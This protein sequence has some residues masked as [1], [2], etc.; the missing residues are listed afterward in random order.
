MTPLLCICV[1]TFNRAPDLANLLAC[2]EREI[3]ARDDVIV[4]ISDNASPD[5]TEALLADAAA[6]LPWLRVFRQSENV[7][8]FANLQWLIDN[9][10]PARYLWLFGD[11]DVIVPGALATI[12]DVLE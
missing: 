3:G 9:A 5:G 8:P 6:R 10:P 1:P 11:D 12:M 4:H 7:G 2:L